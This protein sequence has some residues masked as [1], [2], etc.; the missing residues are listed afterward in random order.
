MTTLCKDVNEPLG[1]LKANWL[2]GLDNSYLKIMTT[3]SSEMR[4]SS[5]SLDNS[6]TGKLNGAAKIS[7]VVLSLMKLLQMTTT[8]T[9]SSCIGALT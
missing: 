7:R 2:F 6:R 1:S 8:C 3:S 5:S 4:T 9:V